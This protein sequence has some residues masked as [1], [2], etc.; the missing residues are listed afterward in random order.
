MFS[1]FVQI[2]LQ[3]LVDNNVME[4]QLIYRVVQ[5]VSFVLLMVFG[6]IGVCSELVLYIIL[7]FSTHIFKVWLYHVLVYVVMEHRFIHVL[8]LHQLVVGWYVLDQHNKYNH[9][10]SINHVQVSLIFNLI[11]LIMIKCS[12]WWVG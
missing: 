5:L 7:Y 9:V 3:L 11:W 6:E 1:A 12:W 10:F 4:Q 8:V 2:Q